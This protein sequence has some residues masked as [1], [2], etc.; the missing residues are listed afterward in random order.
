MHRL[1]SSTLFA[2]LVT[3]A[4]GLA[5]ACA[6]PVQAPKPKQASAAAASPPTQP[7]RP[8]P[9]LIEV[10]VLVV[11]YAGAVGAPAGLTRTK[12]DAE[13]RARMLSRMA[14]SGD[15]LAELVRKY[16]DRQGAAE[17][18]GLFRLR[19]SQPGAFGQAVAN[20]AIAL[21]AAEISDPVDAAEGYFV[22]E[23]RPDPPT[24]PVR[25]GAKHI[26]ISFAG[27][28]H[29]I[30]GVTRSETEAR[31]L[32]DDVAK[33]A[34]A[35]EDWNALAQNTDEPG[36]KETGG[37]LGKFGRGQMVKSFEAAAF[38]LAIGQISD[39]VKSPFGFHVIQR[40]E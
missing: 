13:A 26:L 37:D 24:G 29:A 15:K 5:S 10:R 27:A 35:G 14:R 19:P 20:A 11:T 4:L 33:R 6:P 7:E 21:E 31:A 22:I 25:V 8:V 23:R 38:A 12:Q 3:F 36:S 16:S 18:L 9:E 1:A 39:V 40:Y 34:K 28:E 2:G 32:A 30:A 17:D